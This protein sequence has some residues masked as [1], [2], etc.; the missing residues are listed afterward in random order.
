MTVA[1][2]CCCLAGET[3]HSPGL[4]PQTNT[5]S[6]PTGLAAVVTAAVPPEPTCSAG[7][8]AARDGP[9]GAQAPANWAAVIPKAKATEGE[10]IRTAHIHPAEPQ[11]KEK[12][13]TDVLPMP[14]TL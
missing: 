7:G 3:Y 14:T 6:Q 8:R 10:R 13:P 5:S 4:W 2:T 1:W 12:I 9:V 11:F